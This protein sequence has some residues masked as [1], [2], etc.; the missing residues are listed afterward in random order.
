MTAN[1][2]KNLFSC[3]YQLSSMIQET[4]REIKSKES[5]TS[6]DRRSQRMGGRKQ[7]KSEGSSKVFRAEHDSQEREEDLKNT[8]EVVA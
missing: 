7:K 5:E 4:S 1:I 3:E 2:D 8:K 6:R